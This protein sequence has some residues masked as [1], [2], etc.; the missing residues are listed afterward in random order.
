MDEP[1][2]PSPSRIIASSRVAAGIE[3]CCQVPGKS[4]NFTS[5]TWMFLCLI[6]SRTFCTSVLVDVRVEVVGRMV[7]AMVLSALW[8]QG[9][10]T[11]HKRRCPCVE[12]SNAGASGEHRHDSAPRSR[13]FD[14]ERATVSLA[15]QPQGLGSRSGQVQS[16]HGAL[17]LLE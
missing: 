6:S 14:R 2:N 11:L 3:K 10:R 16:A 12:S 7:V 4:Q 17:I 1:S 8:F 5:T 13:R 9:F 15:R